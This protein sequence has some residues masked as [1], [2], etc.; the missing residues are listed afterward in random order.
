MNILGLSI[1]GV[2][3]LKQGLELR[4]LATTDS[5]YYKYTT[6]DDSYFREDI[7]ISF[8]VRSGVDYTSENVIRQIETLLQNA[9][10][11]RYI[12][13]DF[14]INWLTSYKNTPLFNSTNESAFIS[15]YRVSFLAK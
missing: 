11:E 1:Y 3:N 5:Y 4:N 2:V 15:S 8:V 12:I 14:E 10:Q 6:W 13:S 9:K 7:P